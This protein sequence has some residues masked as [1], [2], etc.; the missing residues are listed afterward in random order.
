MEISKEAV[1]IGSSKT[2]DYVR[3]NAFLAHWALSPHFASIVLPSLSNQTAFDQQF[4]R[5][6]YERIPLYI[7]GGFQES[8]IKLLLIA[9]HMKVDSCYKAL[10][11][12]I[13]SQYSVP[14]SLMQC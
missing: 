4:V 9:K 11:Q 13:F 1:E 7:R 3:V 10:A 5:T 8:L 2:R 12:T 14:S 6:G